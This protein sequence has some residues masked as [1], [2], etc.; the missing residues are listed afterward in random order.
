M[1]IL[2]SHHVLERLFGGFRNRWNGGRVSEKP[3]VEDDVLMALVT[4]KG[5]EFDQKG[6]ARAIIFRQGVQRCA[7]RIDVYRATHYLLLNVSLG[8]SGRTLSYAPNL[9]C[10]RWELLLH[11]AQAI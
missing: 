9:R 8:P 3:K 10:V 6:H 4:F 5:Q 1:K 7:K 2:P 11:V